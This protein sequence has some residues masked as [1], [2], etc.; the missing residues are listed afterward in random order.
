MFASW[1]SVEFKL[2]LITDYQRLKAKEQ[3]LLGWSAKREL[4]KEALAKPL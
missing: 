2:Y 3:E 4:A 1:V